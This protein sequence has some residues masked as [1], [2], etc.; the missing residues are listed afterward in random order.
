MSVFPEGLE[1]ALQAGI[2]RALR[3]HAGLVLALKQGPN[4]E[5]RVYDD[6][7]DKAMLPYIEIGDDDITDE[8][9]TCGALYKANSTIRVFSESIGKAEA[10]TIGSYVRQALDTEIL[11]DGWKVTAGSFVTAVYRPAETP[12]RTE[13]VL[14]FNYEIDPI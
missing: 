12:R 7:P 9:T 3:D 13:G 10:K 6:L 11:I 5:L 1:V 2:Y 14:V 4:G 8:S